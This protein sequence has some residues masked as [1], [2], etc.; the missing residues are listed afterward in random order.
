MTVKETSPRA[1]ATPPARPIP[2]MPLHLSP[3]A[4]RELVMSEDT[5]A[6]VDCGIE[7]PRARGRC[8]SCYRAHIALL[9]EQGRFVALAPGRPAIPAVEK[10]FGRTTPGYG[11]C[12]LYTGRLCIDGY[13]L[14]SKPGSRSTFRAHRV[15]YEAE[16]GPIP[17]GRQIDHLCH[18]QSG[19]CPGG[20]ACLHRRCVNPHHLE[21]VTAEENSRRSVYR[22]SP[23]SSKTHCARGHEYSAENTA[24][25]PRQG[26]YR[27][28]CRQCR[29][30]RRRKAHETAASQAT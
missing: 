3:L 28:R 25:E 18:T 8:D 29:A 21:P 30:A 14:V 12:V 11:G 4:S 9:K 7:F 16:I 20:R 5:K 19:D 13:G 22:D 15:A 1:N 26:G 2:V 24:I 23:H 17:A 27:R 6:C 10:V